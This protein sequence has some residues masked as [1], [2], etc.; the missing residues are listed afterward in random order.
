M[1][2][3]RDY[4]SELKALNERARVLR[5]RR[6]VQLGEL[7]IACGADAVP[8]EQL[9]GELIDAVASKDAA[10]K[11]GW[12]V[13]GAA[14]FQRSTRASPRAADRNGGSAESNEGGKASAPGKASA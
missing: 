11:E 4:D 2:R 10:I 14:F 1:R 8:I 6:L 5:D 12:R 9:A 3:P 13:R 7:V